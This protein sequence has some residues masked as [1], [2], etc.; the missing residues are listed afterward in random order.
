VNRLRRF[1]ALSTLSLVMFTGLAIAQD[2]HRDDS[3]QAVQH[4]NHAYV[5]HDDW[6]QGSRLRTEDWSRGEVVDYRAHHLQKPRHDQQWRLIDGHY[7]MAEIGSGRIGAV[8]RA[9]DQH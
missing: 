3:R 4:D 6:K 5:Q 2:D 9:S 7:V 1:A 8:V